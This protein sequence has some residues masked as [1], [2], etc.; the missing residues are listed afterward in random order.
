MKL[1]HANQWLQILDG[2]TVLEQTTGEKVT[3]GQMKKH[4]FILTVKTC[5]TRKSAE[6][7]VLLAFS[8]REPDGCEFNLQRT[9][10][11]QPLG[12]VES[13]RASRILPVNI[14]KR[15]AFIALRKLFGDRG[16]VA[17]FTRTWRGPWTCRVIGSP[18]RFTAPS[19]TLCIN[20]ED[21]VLNERIENE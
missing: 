19:R 13:R 12:Q 11:S 8:E 10:A 21:E 7:A 9:K 20:W 17:A 6:R 4:K 18:R 5:G 16:K 3:V 15:C 2:K 14:F 1:E